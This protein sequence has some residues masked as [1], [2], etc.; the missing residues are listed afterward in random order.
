MTLVVST[1]TGGSWAAT[2]QTAAGAAIDLSGY[3]I[4]AKILAA[5]TEA[6][7][8][9]ADGGLTTS[10]GGT[11]NATLTWS[12]NDGHGLAAGVYHVQTRYHTGDGNWL[13]L[14]K[15][16]LSIGSKA[17]CSSHKTLCA[18]DGS[19]ATDVVVALVSGFSV[20]DGGAA[21]SSYQGSLIDG[22]TA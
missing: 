10:A 20:I 16:Q 19:V 15:G 7:L 21:D 9:P 1:N 4:E 3:T 14:H 2:F 8:S 5:D 12:L 17:W 18:Y 22:G 6:E 13:D 11:G